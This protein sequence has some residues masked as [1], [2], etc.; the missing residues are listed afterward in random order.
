MRNA[1]SSASGWQLGI[2]LPQRGAQAFRQKRLAKAGP[3]GGG[4][5]GGDDLAMQQGI[6][7]LPKP[8]QRGVLDHGF[9]KVIHIQADLLVYKPKRLGVC[10]FQLINHVLKEYLRPP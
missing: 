6:I 5:A 4:F 2:Q 10:S 1:S 7:Q 8:G 3:L 9:A